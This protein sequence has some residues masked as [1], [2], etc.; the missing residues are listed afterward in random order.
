METESSTRPLQRK[1][2]RRD[3][4]GHLFPVL[5]AHMRDIFYP[6][7]FKELWSLMRLQFQLLWGFCKGE[8]HVFHASTVPSSSLALENVNCWL[9]MYIHTLGLAASQKSH[10]P[11]HLQG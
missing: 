4:D 6:A 5:N 2:L 11:P 8:E 9:I 7:H 10:A 1:K 3:I